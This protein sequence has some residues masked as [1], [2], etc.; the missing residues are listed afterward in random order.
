MSS[1]GHAV[2]N[3]GLARVT[4]TGVSSVRRWSFAQPAPRSSCRKACQTDRFRHAGNG[5]SNCVSKARAPLLVVTA[6]TRSGMTGGVSRASAHTV[7]G[8][9]AGDEPE[10]ARR[11]VFPFVGGGVGGVL[12]AARRTGF[13]F[14]FSMEWQ[15]FRPSFWKLRSYMESRNRKDS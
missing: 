6:T 11:T 7:S 8:K 1:T 3:F 10:T 12:R 15:R 2:P 5:V 4:S 14:D 13:F 9:I